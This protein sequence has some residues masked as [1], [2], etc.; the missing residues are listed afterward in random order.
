MSPRSVEAADAPGES[1]C[2]HGAFVAQLQE[3]F[4]PE[5]DTQYARP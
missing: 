3:K 4:G 2:S 1:L 5:D